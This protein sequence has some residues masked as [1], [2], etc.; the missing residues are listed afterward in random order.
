M[1]GK[2]LVHIYTGDGK[3]KTTAAVGLAVRARGAGLS[4]LLVQFLKG[5]ETAELGPLASLGVEILRDEQTRKFLFYMNAAE[6]AECLR[7][8]HAVFEKAAA[9][10]PRYDLVILDELLGAVAVEAVAL[11]EAARLVRGKPERTELVLTGRDAPDELTGLADYVSEI[12][13]V[14]HPYEQGVGARRGIEF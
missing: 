14:R 9:L 6:R 2:G 10:L 4:V 7:R 8:Q 5:R 13:A 12:R 11:G 1:D 3:G